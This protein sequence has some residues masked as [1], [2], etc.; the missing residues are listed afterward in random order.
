MKVQIL[1]VVLAISLVACEET[2]LEKNFN[3]I[4]FLTCLG[5]GFSIVE[6]NFNKMLEAA[7]SLD[8]VTIGKLWT[9]T[10]NAIKNL[11]TK[12]FSSNDEVE[13]EIK[14]RTSREFICDEKPKECDKQTNG[15]DRSDYKKGKN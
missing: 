3:P 5:D 12:C 11:F 4:E 15:N 1:F 13:L 8:F 6:K 2:S 9:E 10:I 7:K 14:P